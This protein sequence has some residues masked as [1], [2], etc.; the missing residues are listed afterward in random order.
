MTAAIDRWATSGID[1][2]VGVEL[3]RF[4][5]TAVVFV[6]TVPWYTRGCC[7]GMSL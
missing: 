1:G 5:G 7:R 3:D 6:S 2:D 4:G